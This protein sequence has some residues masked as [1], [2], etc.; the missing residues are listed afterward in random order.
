MGKDYDIGRPAGRCAECGKELSPGDEYMAAVREAGEGFDRQDVCLSCWEAKEH[1]EA[2][3]YGVWRARVPRADE[4]K[5]LFVDD[6]VII[7]FFD[8]LEGAEEPAKVNFRF[9]LGLVLMRKKLLVY[10][11]MRAE[12]DGREVWLMHLKGQERQQEV[13]DP[14]MDDEKIADVSRQLNQIMEVEPCD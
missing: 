8:R 13:V 11:R 14:H 3:A 12:P 1:G 4:K 6:E 5:R 7:E 10:D 2:G 9:V